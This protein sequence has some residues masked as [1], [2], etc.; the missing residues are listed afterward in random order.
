MKKQEV[1]TFH[2]LSFSF[3]FLLSG[4]CCKLLV[5]FESTLDFLQ[6]GCIDF[7]L[8]NQF[9]FVGSLVFVLEVEFD[10]QVFFHILNSSR[11]TF[12][13]TNVI[14]VLLQHAIGIAAMVALIKW[15][16]MVAL[17]FKHG[18]SAAQPPGL[19]IAG[20]FLPCVLNAVWAWA[21]HMVAL[22]QEHAKEITKRRIMQ[23]Q[24]EG[25]QR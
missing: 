2:C 5:N 19:G 15:S 24:L 6:H 9:D 10:S 4:I 14:H 11:Q 8:G 23:W 12:L 22:S 20:T 7:F 13:K 3:E 17:S 21:V 1:N 16:R 18:G 25:T